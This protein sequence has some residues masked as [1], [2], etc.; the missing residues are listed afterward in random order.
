[1]G[2]QA[3]YSQ[4]TSQMAHLLLQMR[5]EQEVKM[6]DQ[7]QQVHIKYLQ[8]LLLAND[9]KPVQVKNSQ[10]NN[11]RSIIRQKQDSKVSL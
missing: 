8:T 10:I 9:H 4:S 11:L 3:L 6:D 2:I 5:I 7:S 1:M